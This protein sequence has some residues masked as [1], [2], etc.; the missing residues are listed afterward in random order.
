MDGAQVHP[1]L[2]APVRQ[3][4]LEATSLIEIYKSR[5]RQHAEAKHKQTE[6]R[7]Q[8]I[9]TTVSRKKK[10]LDNEGVANQER[11]R[12]LEQE[13]A[14]VQAREERRAE[15]Y[16]RVEAL[17]EQGA[18]EKMRNEEKEKK[19]LAGLEAEEENFI[20]L[21]FYTKMGNHQGPSP[22]MIPSPEPGEYPLGGG[23]DWEP[24]PE[25]RSGLEAA[26]DEPAGQPQDTEPV[27]SVITIEAPGDQ[28][29]E[30]AKPEVATRRRSQNQTAKDGDKARSPSRKRRRI[31]IDHNVNVTKTVSFDEVYQD[32]NPDYK[33]EIVEFPIH[34]GKWYILHCE[35]HN[36]RFGENKKNAMQGAA[37]HM[38]SA[39]H[40]GTGTFVQHHLALEQF[41]IHVYDCDSEKAKKNNIMVRGETAAVISTFRGIVDPVEGQPY[42][43][44]FNGTWWAL[45]VLPTSDFATVGINGNFQ[46]CGLAR[47]TPKCYRRRSGN[48]PLKWAAGYEDGGPL[49]QGRQ[50]PVRYFGDG[51]KVGWVTAASLRP[52]DPTNVAEDGVVY[53]AAVA[54]EF[55]VNLE[56]FKRLAAEQN[57]AEVADKGRGRITAPPDPRQSVLPS[58]DDDDYGPGSPVREPDIP[59]AEVASPSVLGDYSTPREWSATVDHE[60]ASSMLRREHPDVKPLR[61]PEHTAIAF[62]PVTVTRYRGT[63]NGIP[64]ETEPDES[65]PLVTSDIDETAPGERDTDESMPLITSD[66]DGTQPSSFLSTNFSSAAVAIANDYPFGFSSSTRG[67]SQP[68]AGQIRPSTSSASGS[69]RPMRQGNGIRDTEP[70][71][72]NYTQANGFE[73]RLAETWPQVSSS[74][75]MEATRGR[76][77]AR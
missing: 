35:Q 65:M 31:T 17:A 26:E 23:G 47:K 4:F 66:I 59:E 27:A 57:Q 29:A 56:D 32:G 72:L 58:F 3:K 53:G 74:S 55:Y 62:E 41:G 48:G 69:S 51:G 77:A 24:E 76:S 45:M 19:F 6:W 20:A 14:N 5:R 22:L 46:K 64:E 70:P 11:I 71:G 49:V 10:K 63:P 18:R 52:F 36:L 42:S 61:S 9:D 68:Q 16:G 40:G 54:R 8:K 44:S 12:W 25:P 34:A 21:T 67:L 75:Q 7:N 13:L 38:G 15:E 39:D 73:S 33:F 37:K 2:P 28:T 43:T 50:F 1:G 60:A 30:Q